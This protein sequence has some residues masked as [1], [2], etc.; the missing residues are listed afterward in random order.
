M[1]VCS[2]LRDHAMTLKCTVGTRGCSDRTGSGNK[3]AAAAKLPW[4]VALLSASLSNAASAQTSTLD[5]SGTW[6]ARHYAT[7]MVDEVTHSED[8]QDKRVFQI[9][10]D[11]AS[12]QVSTR[13]P[14]LTPE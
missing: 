10:H 5:F 1:P 6:I 14:D 12:T 13:I 11:R 9:L 8:A 4:L 2:E 7:I 3:E